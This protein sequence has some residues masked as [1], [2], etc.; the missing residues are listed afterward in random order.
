MKNTNWNQ[1][2]LFYRLAQSSSLKEAA[3]SLKLSV[4]SVS[5]QLARLEKDLKIQLIERNPRLFRLSPEGQRLYRRLQNNFQSNPFS[6]ELPERMVESLHIGLVPGLSFPICFDII[7]QI[8][9]LKKPHTLKVLQFTHESLERA[10]WS[11]EIQIGFSTR[12]IRL[13]SLKHLS[14]ERFRFALFAHK[15]LHKHRSEALLKKY[16]V[17]LFKDDFLSEKIQ[18]RLILRFPQIQISFIETDYPSLAIE[19]CNQKDAITVLPLTG[20]SR[21][22]QLHSELTLIH[23]STHL[24]SSS[25]KLYVAGFDLKTLFN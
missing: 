17:A 22:A 3:N 6:E 12:S 25:E 13:R 23:D 5:E 8:H 21:E 19:L 14:I 15:S 20:H 10:L 16:P 24:F 2:Y 1:L 7:R 9:K 4:S 11:G 18:E